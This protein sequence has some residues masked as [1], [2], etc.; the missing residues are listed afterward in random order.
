MESGKFSTRGTSDEE[1]LSLHL[2]TIDMEAMEVTEATE[3]TKLIQL[4]ITIERTSAI[5]ESEKDDDIQRQHKR[6]CKHKRSWRSKTSPRLMTG[7]LRSTPSWPRLTV[8]STSSKSGTTTTTEKRERKEQL[9]F[10][11]ELHKTRMKH[12]TELQTAKTEHVTQAASNS[13]PS[14]SKSIRGL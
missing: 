6:Q 4:R 7:M 14:W 2:K 3:E 1:K 9:K 13:N 10:K 11:Q 8:K 12:Q 5:L